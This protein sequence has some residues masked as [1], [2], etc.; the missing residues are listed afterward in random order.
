MHTR[1]DEKGPDHTDA[2]VVLNAPCLWHPAT[3]FDD[4]ASWWSSL[5]LPSSALARLR[6]SQ[7]TAAG[8]SPRSPARRGLNPR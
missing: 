1:P 6:F 2:R 4:R 5:V 7:D 3:C 8:R